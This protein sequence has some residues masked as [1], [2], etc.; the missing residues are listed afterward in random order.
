MI[1]KV[2]NLFGGPGTGKSTCA[3]GLFYLMKKDGICCE[4]SNEWIKEKVYEGNNYVFSDQMYV[5][6]KQRKKL[7]Q[8]V[9]KVEYI[10]TDSPLL[11]SVIYG[12][13]SGTFNSLVVEEFNR[14]INF[15]FLI[16]R[17]HQYQT[18]GR[19][20]NEDQAQGISQRIA[21]M[22]NYKQVEYSEIVSNNSAEEIYE[23][24]KRGK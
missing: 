16:V 19:V 24:M 5:F 2:I 23:L 1:T 18:Y 14:F 10:V 15:N 21:S 13:E 22:L 12:K 9:G 3:S 6:A 8:L 17:N 20:Q 4:I 11:L 7:M